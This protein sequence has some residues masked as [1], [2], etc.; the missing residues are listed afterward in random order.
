M[1]SVFAKYISKFAYSKYILLINV[2]DRL[3]SF[4]ILLLLARNFTT[5]IYGQVITL[6]SLSMI[7]I[8]IFDL[9]LPTYMQREISINPSNASIVF[10]KIFSSNLLFFIFNFLFGFIACK[11]LYPSIPFFLFL[12]IFLMIYGAS[13]VTLCNKALSGLNEFKSQFAAFS[14]PRILILT[15]FIF[16]LLYASFELNLLMLIMFL[17]F[18]LNLVLAIINLKRINVKF[19]PD[20]FAPKDLSLILKLTLPLGIAVIFNFLYDKIDII[21][22]SKLKDFSEAA[23]Y[24]I[25]YGLFKGA[26]LSFS[27]LLVP[28]FT[29]ISSIGKDKK[30]A[31]EFFREYARIIV[32]I[33]IFLGLILFWGSELIIKTLYTEKF[34]NSIT[35]LKILAFGLLG[36]GL[37]NLTGTVL[38]GMGYFKIVMYVTM[39]GLIANAVLNI[40]FIPA[41]GIIAASVITVITE[42][43]IFFTELYY[44]R[45]ILNK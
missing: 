4:I 11:L 38:N 42:Y 16:G 10:S 31:G 19:N 32:T 15:F 44:F 22:I 26:S 17:G 25:G 41:Y 40:A 8:T 27:F 24:G 39:Y 36:L 9:G 5:E 12:I 28:G 21:L 18:S 43:F 7:S 20:Y 6:F 2:A 13:L 34:F 30:Q 1:K 35:V 33:C 23:F 29:K 14:I 3:F 45:K 37:N